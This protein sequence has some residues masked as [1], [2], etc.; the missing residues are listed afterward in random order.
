MHVIVTL[1]GHSRRFAQAG[2]TV[3]KALIPIGGKPMIAHVV[4]MFADNDHFHFVLNTQQAKDFPELPELL[5]SLARRVSLTIVEPHEKGPTYSALCTDVPD[6][7]EVIV[8]YCDFTVDWNY[9]RFLRAVRGYDGAVPTFRGF[10]PASYGKTLYAYLRTE[11]TTMLEL[12]EKASF[13][14]DRASEPAS[15]GVYYFRSMGLFRR[16]A[17]RLLDRI[18]GTGQ[19]AYASLMFND[20]VEDGLHVVI[21]DVDRF[22]CLGTP[23]DVAQYQFWHRVFAEPLPERIEPPAP[24]PGRPRRVNLLP[25]A[26]RG[27]RFRKEGYRLAKPLIPIRGRPM[28]VRAA[29]SFPS[30]DLWIFLP[31]AEDL[32]R[33]P[34]ERTFEKFFPDAHAIVPVDHETSGQAATCLLAEAIYRPDDEL[35]IASCDYQTRY[36]AAAW[37]AVLADP[38]IDGAVW[39][40]RLGAML[41]A[42]PDAFAYCR[43]GADG[44][45]ITEI[46][47]KRR[48]SDDPGADPMVVGSFW[49]R[50]A[51]D[52]MMGARRMMERGI[53]VN[54]EHYVGTSIN[55]LV[56]AGR[57]FVIFEVEQWISFGDPF[58][59]KVYEYWEEYFHKRGR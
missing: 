1:A 27:S 15:T 42:N 52:F 18:L 20:M 34:L 38:S 30:A 4:D 7:E 43:V 19:E 47:E 51:G 56:E 36:D 11:G 22:I 31:R 32:D 55:Q 46:V 58:E 10:H 24:A 37:E 45:T 26:G 28:M 13:T 25:M 50:R 14:E 40:C 23:E 44:K 35:F 3:P 53:T 5:K 16:Y 41:T 33:H 54:G 39:T 17:Q 12:R 49:Y 59:L 2:Y 57:K 21:Y 8:T 29:E 9:D 6:G 48:I